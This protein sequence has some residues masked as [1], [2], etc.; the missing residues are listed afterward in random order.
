MTLLVLLCSNDDF[1]YA[2]VIDCFG[3]MLAGYRIIENTGDAQLL[4][5]TL[6]ENIDTYEELISK[7]DIV[8]GG[9]K[10]HQ[11]RIWR[12]LRQMSQCTLGNLSAW[13]EVWKRWK[14]ITPRIDGDYISKDSTSSITTAKDSG[15][16]MG[17]HGSISLSAF[18]AHGDSGSTST[19][20][21]GLSSKHLSSATSE[22]STPKCDDDPTA[23]WEYYTGFLS[24]LAQ[25]C[26]ATNNDE[27]QFIPGS[28]HYSKGHQDY[29]P[30]SSTST[31]PSVGSDQHRTGEGTSSLRPYEIMADEFVGSMVDLLVC[32][33]LMVRER[34]REIMGGDMTPALYWLMMNHFKI[35]MNACFDKKKPIYDA[36]RILFVEQSISVLRIMLGRS[37]SADA[38]VVVD[39]TELITQFCTY[40]NAL[41]D[42][43]TS[44]K[45]KIKL[46]HFCGSLLSQRNQLSLHKNIAVRT[47]LLKCLHQWT[48]NFDFKSP[49]S[50][51]CQS[52]QQE[53]NL[54]HN[55]TQILHHHHQRQ[56]QDHE[57]EHQ[58]HE[59]QL[60]GKGKSLTVEDNLQIDLDMA[61][62]KTMVV[63]L[64]QLPLQPTKPTRGV[65]MIQ[66]K[67]KMFFKYFAFLLQL[68]DRCKA[69]AAVKD[70]DDS[71]APTSI[72][73][74]TI[75]T[76]KDNI[77]LCLSNLLS[78]NV[79]VGLKYSL[80]MGYHQD[81][82]TRSA[83]M[84]VLTN[85]LKQGTE[86]ENLAETI[87]SD[88]YA[89]LV[90]MLFKFDCAIT[91]SL[92]NVAPHSEI[93]NVATA[94]LASFA[95]EKKSLVL[96][97]MLVKSE[98]QNTINESDLF[99]KTSIATKCLTLFA[100]ANGSSYVVKVLKPVI[101]QL[102][103]WSPQHQLFELDPANVS[104][105]YDKRNKDHV[106]SACNLILD[107]ICNSIDMA[108][109]CIRS[110]CNLI[111]EAVKDRFSESK[112]TAVG[113]FIFLRFFCPVIVSPESAG[114]VK[115]GAINKCL[116]RGLLL[117][118]KVIQNIANNVL[119]GAK[120]VY[121]VVLNDFVTE[122]MYR[123]ISYLRT[124]AY[125]DINNSEMPTNTDVGI[126][127]RM[128][129]ADH[130]LLHSVL[131]KNFENIQHDLNT[132]KLLMFDSQD[133]MKVWNSY[134]EEF[135]ML[136][137]QLGPPSEAMRHMENFSL[138]T[139]HVTKDKSRKYSEFM[140]RNANRNT[141][142]IASNNICYAGGSSL[143]GH[144][145][146]YF[147]LRRVRAEEIEMELLM[148]HIFQVIENLFGKPFDVVLD[149]TQFGPA[150]EISQK[151]A[152]QFAEL[153]P[154]SMVGNMISI[155][156]YN[157][158][159]WFRKYLKMSHFPAPDA[160]VKRIAFA[161]N[162]KEL[163]EFIHP[164]QVQLPKSTV[165]LEKEPSTAF[166]HVSRILQFNME[167][168]VTIRVGAEYIQIICDKKQEM[169]FGG[170]AVTNDVY[171]ISELQGITCSGN[172][173]EN[174]YQVSFTT[175][176][177]RMVVY[178]RT[179]KYKQ[180]LQ[181]ILQ[182][183]GRYDA[184]KP[185]TLSNRIIR[186]SDVPGRLL[187]MALLNLGSSDSRLRL[188]AY[189]LLYTL[190]RTFNFNVGTNLLDAKELCLPPNCFKFVAKISGRLAHTEKQLTLE[191]LNEC[192]VG[193]EKSTEEQRYLCLHYM[194]PWIPN[195][196]GTSHG[197]LEEVTRTKEI[198]RMLIGITVKNIHIS[199]QTKLWK[200]LGSVGSVRDIVL[201][202]SL[203]ISKEYGLGSHEAESMADT[204]VTLSNIQ[205]RTKLVAN[206]MR[207]L[208]RT[209]DT[210]TKSLMNHP[211]WPDIAIMTRFNLMLSFDN[212]GPMKNY[213][214]DILHMVTLL[215][216][217]G[218]TLIRTTIH[219][220]TINL[221][222]SLCS[223]PKL[224]DENRKELQQ[225][226]SQ[227]GGKRTHLMFG[228]VKPYANAFTNQPDT[229]N[230]PLIEH[231]DLSILQ[232]IITI[233]LRVL[234][235]GAPTTDICNAW[236]S[237]WMGHI[238]SAVFQSNLAI[239]PRLFVG[240]G[241]LGRQQMNDDII[242]QTLYSLQQ[243]LLTFDPE[244][245]SLVLS[246]TM[247]LRNLVECVRSDS[248]Y[249]IT[250]FWV[251][252]GLLSIN[253]QSLVITAT[254]LLQGTLNTMEA[255]HLF[256]E[257]EAAMKNL[258]FN[259]MA[260][261]HEIC[262]KLD[263]LN[264][265]NFNTHFSFAV[266][267]ILMKAYTTP[268][269]KDVAFQCLLTFL[270]CATR[271]E[272]EKVDES[273]L[274]YVASLISVARQ[275]QSSQDILQFAGV[276]WC[277]IRKPSGNSQRNHRY[278]DDPDIYYSSDGGGGSS[279]S[280]GN[281]GRTSSTASTNE[282]HFSLSRAPRRNIRTAW[283]SNTSN[284]FSKL[285]LPDDDTAL[286]FL[287]CL[288][289][290]L[291]N[292]VDESER[293]FLY[294]VLSDAATIMPDVF[295]I[296]YPTM[297]PR[298]NQLIETSDSIPLLKAIQS[299]LM[300][301]NSDSRFQYPQATLKD[302][303]VSLGFSV[304]DEPSRPMSPSQMIETAGLVAQ[305]V[306]MAIS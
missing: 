124:M 234:E 20:T 140:Q 137:I 71:A 244:Y 249:Q 231:F 183:K 19:S 235:I 78:A 101:D 275:A 171:H 201:D 218:P 194:T 147:I 130:R 37:E 287:S 282:Q 57:K 281:S 66:Q 45:I 9:R 168:P 96:L 254:E 303:L 227:I 15:N 72:N 253:H 274:G 43:D 54:Q 38:L 190:C 119:F 285:D 144:C 203:D 267:G 88:R 299:I 272:K 123:V 120:E 277:S 283:C 273:V 80:S 211:L 288:V 61:C 85:I 127:P 300:T 82:Q 153:M 185:S 139:Q 74:S 192:F 146:I 219:G 200:T 292:A 11:K 84:Q 14:R 77:I 69:S 62:L 252:L 214:P 5:F 197:T 155:I 247:C 31:S 133:S 55:Q 205:V 189:N 237:R 220:I 167:I 186:P 24:S 22:A 126:S 250:L 228:I 293:L 302:R 268:R 222:Q 117:I 104:R 2:R 100:R 112:Y 291:K 174:A 90:S 98:V 122:N 193:F 59:Q 156:I 233:L 136:L 217:V 264:A 28:P 10:S 25:V 67:S 258:L 115:A 305:M 271:H 129:D 259:S 221:I 179:P 238:S 116:R 108:P 248:R 184:V 187:N 125:A 266:S 296:V 53:T 63:I 13:E 6:F 229:L 73:R 246:I 278:S 12:I 99:R 160:I 40:I 260:P 39:F 23:E 265:I 306:K 34:V 177:D 289:A 164:S 280:S 75:G 162:L 128:N 163:A 1:I 79:D 138:Q 18:K 255:D 196:G 157:S 304:F 131:V 301:A 295:S 158:N 198:L 65:T 3:L 87:V 143:T 269:G 49:D 86:F 36:K 150:N 215:V 60:K 166:F 102:I 83:F 199:I 70:G 223:S 118:A 113:C 64:H 48:S 95:S 242:Y 26:L 7:L 175:S 89:K 151:C 47:L 176:M 256:D 230:D 226:M 290:Q 173:G 209:T 132:K 154:K 121:M 297:L 161:V 106:I 109:D 182:C 210:P 191:F 276:H 44:K 145:V 245:P 142:T 239:Q 56:Q 50:L 68:L 169:V 195:L 224:P 8:P 114:L 17:Q 149:V 21:G 178:L 94:L 152:T 284:L 262:N 212:C 180:L 165:A 243:A 32:D 148:Y 110:V 216:G 42:N 294:E 181:A 141:D 279:K 58:Q 135:S 286:L 261:Y 33:N 298:M 251:A 27:I 236:R 46:C 111:F 208:R 103:R 93:D 97:Q 170:Y 30:P 232:T 81:I 204:C 202:V 257:G 92:F 51:W 207:L 105:G 35:Y 240:L 29:K 263:Q 91:V 16:D 241:C 172:Y 134:V 270:N 76:F 206:T 107:A 4:R 41:D 213:V 52:P 159:T 225:L 188:A